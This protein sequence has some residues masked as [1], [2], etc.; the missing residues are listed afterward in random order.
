MKYLKGL[1]FVVLCIPSWMFA[2]NMLEEKMSASLQESLFQVP[3]E[4]HRVHLILKDQV[5][6]D[7][8]RA[9]FDRIGLSYPER[10]VLLNKALRT[11]ANQTQEAVLSKIR[12]YST[13][14]LPYHKAH[15]IVNAIYV[16]AVPSTII[17]LA[18]LNDIEYVQAGGQ[19]IA[20]ETSD[21]GPSSAMVMNTE[22]T[23]FTI[24][25]HKMW[26]LGYT[27]YGQVC[28]TADTGVD[29]YHP[30]L[31]SQQ[32]ASLEDQFGHAFYHDN[33]SEYS[34]DCG[35]HGTHVTGTILG[36]DRHQDDTIGVAFNGQWMGAG[37]LCGIGTA[38]NVDAF[39]W[40]MDPDGN[41]DTV[42]DMPDV[43][44]NSWYDPT[45][46]DAC[47]NVYMTMLTAVEM[48]GIAIVFSAGNEGS[49]SGTITNPKN[50]NM[51]LVNTFAVGA[52]NNA[53]TD[54]TNFSSRGPSQCF[55][56]DSSLY[57]KPEVSAP[58]QSVR[59]C[60][61]GNMYGYKSGTSMAAPHVAGAL[62]L[63][64]EAFPYLSGEELKLALYYTAVDMGAPGEDNVFGM[65][66]IDVFAAYEYL[67]GQ[68]LSPA[69]PSVNTD[70]MLFGLE[71]SN[72]Q[73]EG[74]IGFSVGIENGGSDTLAGF[75]IVAEFAGETQSWLFEDVVLVPGARYFFDTDSMST[76][77]GVHYL[78]VEGFLMDTGIDQRPLNNRIVTRVEHV[79]DY[80][81]SFETSTTAPCIGSTVSVI[82]SLDGSTAGKFEWYSDENLLNQIGTGTVLN[83][84]MDE[85]EQTVYAKALLGGTYG[86]KIDQ[87]YQSIDNGAGKGLAIQASEDAFLRSMKVNSSNGGTI[88]V[89]VY[90][91]DGEIVKSI[92]N[93]VAAGVNEIFVGIE[94]E[95]NDRYD[96]EL[97]TGAAKLMAH[98]FDLPYST[99][100]DLLDILSGLDNGAQVADWYYFFYDFVV[101][102]DVECGV[103]QVDLTADG[104]G[105]VSID[106]IA[107]SQDQFNIVTEYPTI[108]PMATWTGDYET[109]EWDFG[110][111]NTSS[112]IEP[113]HTY[114]SAGTYL[115]TLTLTDAAGCSSTFIKEVQ[116]NS[117][118]T[119]VNQVGD[120]N[121]FTVY[122]NPT[123]GVLFVSGAKM[124]EIRLVDMHG[125]I[126]MQFES[127]RTQEELDLGDWPAGVYFIQ[128]KS[129]ETTWTSKVIR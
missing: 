46:D 95:A 34:Y 93:I 86:A 116:V 47:Q 101:E 68:G 42:E 40:A 22:N 84:E 121:A 19:L 87:A 100:G 31:I 52:L 128:I 54:I 55:S 114:T 29:P 32:R 117:F 15:W 112:E 129:G 83:I 13:D 99:G 127:N 58:G 103:F 57:I 4:I 7:V 124:D 123:D 39:E 72:Y 105:A 60:E 118:L 111:G 78:S 12:T 64:K 59:S 2:Q 92:V 5:D 106:D 18:A 70:L 63:L 53:G 85:A 62:M 98:D 119:G 20:D 11:K 76:A 96:V 77:L 120:P 10:S 37:V 90:D 104:T 109:V 38:D 41:P 97:F 74:T 75:E 61:P 115:L 6:L 56:S 110:D 125:R 1:I 108:N 67:L 79:A 14:D 65:G 27:G 3:D 48:A 73:C 50:L 69:D 44:N 36:L 21:V 80:P 94:L 81:A 71:T 126:L 49:S 122:P 91:E 28:L 102:R 25:A 9:D 35:D 43:V 8:M 23:L 82:G 88:I 51:G 24:N 26:E 17:D 107:L 16:E 30:S 33:G 89:R 45:V 66:I 113:S